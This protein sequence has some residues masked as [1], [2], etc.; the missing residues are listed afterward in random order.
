MLQ[1]VINELERN[2]SLDPLKKLKKENLVNVAAHFGLIPAAGATKSHIL[3]LIED[4]CI[5]NNLID[6]VEEK[7]TVE[8]AEFLKLKLEF[9]REE[10]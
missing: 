10:Q 3:Y 6:E 5:E 2:C 1:N 7:P 4:Y 8:T 9:E